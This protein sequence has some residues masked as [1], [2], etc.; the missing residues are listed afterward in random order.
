MNK[1]SNYIGTKIVEVRGMILESGG[2]SCLYRDTFA[3]AHTRPNRAN[4]WW[5]EESVHGALPNHIPE[6]LSVV[7]K[8]SYVYLDRWK[9]WEYQWAPSF[10][11]NSF[12]AL[13][14]LSLFGFFFI[15]L[16]VKL[17][18]F[19]ILSYVSSIPIVSKIAIS[20][21]MCVI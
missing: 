11:P 5:Y 4:L 16:F 20:I 9:Q 12:Y 2:K 8:S 18:W 6:A 21:V 14:F 13:F 17:C 7:F 19:H 10:Y 1:Y 15:N 3:N